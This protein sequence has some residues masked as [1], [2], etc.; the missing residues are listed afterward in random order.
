MRI[1]NFST[2]A[3]GF[4]AA[5]FTMAC[6]DAVVPTS[7]GSNGR[8][9]ITTAGLEY[10]GLTGATFMLTVTDSLGA[11]V[12]HNSSVSSDDYGTPD[13]RILFIAPCSAGN[14]DTP[15]VGAMG[16]EEN[17]VRVQLL[18]V[19]AAGGQVLTPASGDVHFPPAI[20]KVIICTENAD[21]RADFLLTFVRRAQ[22]GFADVVVA[23][24][25][26]FCS[27]KVSCEDDLMADP[28][29]PYAPG[30]TLVTGFAC[31]DGEVAGDGANYV[32][33]IGTLCCDGAV[34]GDAGC[35]TLD[36]DPATGGPVWSDMGAGVLDTR[37]YMDA[38]AILG[39]VF[40]N[41]SWRLNP[42]AIGDGCTFSARGHFN[43]SDDGAV[44]DFA[45][46]PGGDG[47]S[48]APAFFF[49]TAIGTSDE[50]GD[51]VCDDPTVEV[52]FGPELP[53]GPPEGPIIDV[54]VDTVRGASLRLRRSNSG[55]E[56]FLGVGDLGAS[57]NQPELGMRVEA[58]YPPGHGNH[59]VDH[60]DYQVMFSYVPGSGLFASVHHGDEDHTSLAF[61]QASLSPPGCP[62][63]Q[64]DRLE[65]WAR[66][67]AGPNQST[68]QLLD[69]R[70]ASLTVDPASGF[71]I[72][73][74]IA[75]TN[76]MTWG[77]IGFDYAAGFVLTGTLSVSNWDV[78]NA[79]GSKLEI[80]VHCS[81]GP[82]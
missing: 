31:T 10:P 60:I 66:G 78:G 30:P 7:D 41:T 73:D 81:E 55:S 48:P 53:G 35:T 44:T 50:T 69:V 5:L 68:V 21:V 42:E 40:H 16:T 32:G 79:E 20:A 8:V 12:Y 18:E 11:T 43:W 24:Q 56:F 14:G 6:A 80:G 49:T 36:I 29:P 38:E 4:A 57:P 15:G 54:P 47:V 3:I 25:D 82:I 13:G 27:Y 67:D 33:F 75:G 63:E 28:A 74:L 76:S 65:F 62:P 61:P 9:E 64:W 71:L 52:H 17:T 2:L 45:Y 58:E 77:V 19:R 37:S 23:V 39:K 59:W 26:I 46:A 22:Q 70:L 51:I 34:P 72:G 1:T